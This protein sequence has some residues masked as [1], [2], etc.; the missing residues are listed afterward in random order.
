MSTDNT[1]S[2]EEKYSS[3]LPTKHEHAS[4]SN[5]GSLSGSQLEYDYSEPTHDDENLVQSVDKDSSQEDN[6]AVQVEVDKEANSTTKAEYIFLSSPPEIDRCDS[7]AISDI[8]SESD[9]N[10]SRNIGDL[11]SSIE[12]ATKKVN[13]KLEKLQDSH[14]EEDFFASRETL[15]PS[16]HP[17]DNMESARRSSDTPDSVYNEAT[18]VAGQYQQQ[19]H[20]MPDVMARHPFIDA[21]T[22]IMMVPSQHLLQQ[23]HQQQMHQAQQM[24]MNFVPHQNLNSGLT[25]PMY[26]TTAAHPHAAAHNGN[27]IMVHAPAQQNSGRRTMKLRLLEEIQTV[28]DQNGASEGSRRSIFARV[29]VLARRNR[30]M[31]M[32]DYELDDNQEVEPDSSPQRV[33]TTED[34]GE[35]TISWYDGTSAVELQDHV[36]KSA[37][38]KLRLGRKKLLLNLRVIDENVT[39]PEGK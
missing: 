28:L 9:M 21:N 39:P 36:R 7:M 35:L 2:K 37:E 16:R 1:A 4:K 25:T 18:G 5:T 22:P 30:T 29:S 10:D 15:T 17:E 20:Q 24:Q 27:P 34:R 31:S 32:G 26:T 13:E 33:K 12:N 14:N 19:P 11:L 3:D 23:M 6:G 8:D 38:I